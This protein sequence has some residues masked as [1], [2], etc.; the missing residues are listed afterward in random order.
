MCQDEKKDEEENLI[1]SGIAGA[2]YETVQRY[3][4][5][6][7]EH[8]V[9]YSGVDN[10]K[11][12]KLQKSLKTI[13]N[14]KTNEEYAFSIKQQKAG[15]AAEVIDTANSN[16]KYIIEGDYKRKIRHDD[17]PNMP[18]NHP[19][20]DHVE[21]NVEGD[22]I[23]GSGTQMK[24][25]G[26]ARTNPNASGNAERSIN[27]LLSPKFQKYIDNNVKIEVPK[28]EYPQ[29]IIKANEKAYL[30][31]KQLDAAKKQGRTA[32]AIEIEKKL[33]NVKKLRKNLK[34]STLTRK[35]SLE[36]VDMPRLS[37]VKSI[38]NIAHKAGMQTATTSALIGGSA[39]LIRNFVDLY[40]G[41]VEAGEAAKNIV[42]DTA[43]S[44]AVGYGTGFVGTAVKAQM[45]SSKSE[46][47]RAISKTNV[48]GTIVSV[49]VSA[50]KTLKRYFSKEIDGTQCLEELGE[51]GTGMLTS[52]MLA[53][54]GQ[55]AIPIPVVGGLIGGML[56][57]AL[58][59]ASYSVLLTSLKEAKMAHEERLAIEKACEEHI[60]MIKEYRAEI[61]AVIE[62]YLSE[63]IEVFNE[64]FDGINNALAIGD[65]DWFIESANNITKAF[66]GKNSFENLEEFRTQLL[67]DEVFEL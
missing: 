30:L 8:I 10:E 2:A 24:F 38:T 46:F 3:G 54:V 6:A 53:V 44:A 34:P 41:E 49:A 14:Q 40:K 12:I 66:G 5:A 65:V 51:Q 62:K 50:S 36:A 31:E 4:S 35:E 59:S 26:A 58:S 27:K 21:I 23:A 55:A 48:A 25:I 13:K 39:A 42:K 15:W 45:Q 63:T 17:L 18:A 32:D 22:I 20:Y 19:L 67:S 43:E 29:M 60:Q 33:E 57:Y 64:S 52:S 9:A 61:N 56:G 47:I 7:K 28:D 16:E 1:R 11:G 37:T